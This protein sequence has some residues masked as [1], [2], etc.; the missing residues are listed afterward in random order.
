MIHAFRIKLLVIGCSL[1]LL[2]LAMCWLATDQF[3]QHKPEPAPSDFSL[4]KACALTLDS[5]A[6]SIQLVRQCADGPLIE[7]LRRALE[8]DLQSTTVLTDFTCNLGGRLHW[9]ADVHNFGYSVDSPQAQIAALVVKGTLSRAAAER[10]HCC[11]ETNNLRSSK[12]P[13]HPFLQAQ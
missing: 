3:A 1:L 6:D 12:H 2:L 11:L 5:A 8:E 7:H 4:A 10:I 9:K 13:I